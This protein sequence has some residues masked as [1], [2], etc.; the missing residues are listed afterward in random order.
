MSTPVTPSGFLPTASTADARMFTGT[1]VRSNA[2]A[3][4]SS[5][6]WIEPVPWIVPGMSSV[7]ASFV[8]CRSWSVGPS[9]RPRTRTA[10][11]VT[12]PKSTPSPTSTSRKVGL[13]RLTRN[14]STRSSSSSGGAA[15]SA[16][17]GTSSVYPR[18]GSKTGSGTYSRAP[19]APLVP[20]WERTPMAL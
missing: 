20:H 11:T 16:P 4:P 2:P 14:P 7:A 12:M 5:V 9:S 8:T 19:G 6:N 13:S 18:L 17:A 3:N 1:I 15:L 10:S